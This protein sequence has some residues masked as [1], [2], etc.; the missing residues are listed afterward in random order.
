MCV[1]Q[2]GGGGAGL[3]PPPSSS[4][5]GS[6]MQTSPLDVCSPEARERAPLGL[7]GEAVPASAVLLLQQCLQTKWGECK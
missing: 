5:G 3:V 4:S 1:L 6:S 7:Q 2:G